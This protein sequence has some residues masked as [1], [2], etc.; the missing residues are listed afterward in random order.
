MGEQNEPYLVDGGA[1][2]SMVER[3]GTAMV[4]TQL[5]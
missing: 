5:T 2:W 1:K 4:E 3:S